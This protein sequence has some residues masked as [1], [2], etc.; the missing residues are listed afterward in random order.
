M[1]TYRASRNN[2]DVVR[3]EE[4]SEKEQKKES[5]AKAVDV[6]LETGLDIYTAGAFS[7]VKNTVT[8]VP[9]VGKMA[10]KKWD[11]SVN[12]AAGMFYL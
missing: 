6:G 1:G 8:S 4:K 5:T 9:I 11:K 2:N 3:E 12:K 10:Q 7:K